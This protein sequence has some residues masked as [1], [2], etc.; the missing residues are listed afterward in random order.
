MTSVRH[1]D[2]QQLIGMAAAFA[3]LP[4]K[5]LW[6]LTPKEIPDASAIA[7]LKLSNNTK[8]GMPLIS[9]R[10]P[11]SCMCEVLQTTRS[12]AT[13]DVR[14]WLSHA[15]YGRQLGNQQRLL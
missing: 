4:C 2:K 1:A 12:S 8:V 6:R 15:S 9:H 11:I 5:V 7:E 10:S 14:Q 3:T 13:Q